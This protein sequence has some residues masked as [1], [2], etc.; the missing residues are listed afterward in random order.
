M[1]TLICLVSLSMGLH[2]CCLE[3]S[4]L[5][6]V[7]LCLRMSKSSSL[8]DL[9]E[10]IKHRF[11]VPTCQVNVWNNNVFTLCTSLVLRFYCLFDFRNLGTRLEHFK[12]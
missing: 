5:L 4:V 9:L 3:F 8:G 2:L 1:A 10:L 6:Q 12:G 11:H 7:R